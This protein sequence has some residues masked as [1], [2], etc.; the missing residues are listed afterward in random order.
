MRWPVKRFE[1]FFHRFLIREA[2]DELRTARDRML[3][4]IDCN[5]NWDNKE[6]LP[7]RRERIEGIHRSYKE[8][9]E[10]LWGTLSGN[11]ERSKQPDPME[12]DPLFR[13]LR[14]QAYEMSTS[15]GPPVPE[16]AGRGAALIG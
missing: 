16:E 3:L 10:F 15:I 14:D 8:G 7:A 1:H 11:R 4:A 9:V 2:C 5:P 12:S 6:A 13:S